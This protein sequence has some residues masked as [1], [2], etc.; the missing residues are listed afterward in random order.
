MTITIAISAKNEKDIIRS[1]F[2]SINNQTVK[3][4]YVFLIVDTKDDNTIP[5]AD[6][7]G[8]TT[9]INDGIKLYKARNTA[10]K[11]CKTDLLAFTDADCVLDSKWVENIIKLMKEKPEVVAGTG[12]HPMIGKHNFSS[13]LHHMWFVVEAKETGYTTGVI[14]GNSYFRTQ[15]LKDIGG[16]LNVELMA[17]EDVYISNKIQEA[18]YK[19]WL[20]K[21]IIANHHYKSEFGGFMR[22]TV[23]MGRDI[24]SM[25]KISGIKGWLWWYTMAIPMLAIIMGLS[26]LNASNDSLL[27]KLSVIIILV[28]TFFYWFK[29]FGSLEKALPRWIA[30]WIIIWPYSWGVIKGV[31]GK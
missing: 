11:H 13:W 29:S 21:E 6:E 16:W 31:F 2:D 9:Y 18:G 8:F 5:I 28:S 30:R 23:M 27:G 19:I 4:D 17:A 20:D 14:G 25:M 10:L 24:V 22:Q 1:C 3:A 7:Y 15:V 26:L 12:A